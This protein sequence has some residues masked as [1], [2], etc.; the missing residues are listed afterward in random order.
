MA[1]LRK[2]EGRREEEFG[3]SGREEGVVDAALLRLNDDLLS[4]SFSLSFI[5]LCFFYFSLFLIAHK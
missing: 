2:K 1:S 5:F 3:S 4:L